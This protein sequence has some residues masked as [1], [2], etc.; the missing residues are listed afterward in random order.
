MIRIEA[1]RFGE[2]PA[3]PEY[4][5][6]LV[7]HADLWRG[8]YRT[9]QVPADS[10]LAA[11]Q[12]GVSWRLLALSEDWCGDAV[13]TLPIIARFAESAGLD[14][15]VLGRDANP[16]LMDR[17]LT[18]GS[19]S[20]PVVMVLDEDYQERGWWGPRPAMVQR[21]MRSEA[22]LLPKEERNRRKRAWYARD[23]GRTTIAEVVEVIQRAARRRR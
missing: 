5:E 18:S 2:A 20:I 1:A 4:L 11:R 16:D 7:T 22:L 10:V 21:W 23:R 8:V 9:A 3:F 15:R 19:R 14:V 13:S 17:H 12:T 6:S